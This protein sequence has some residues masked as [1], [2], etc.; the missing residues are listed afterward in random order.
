MTQLKRTLRRH[1][2]LALLLLV[3]IGMAVMLNHVLTDQSLAPVVDNL[4]IPSVEPVSLQTRAPTSSSTYAV[5]TERPLFNPGRR[6]VEA[7]VV[8]A[9]PPAPVKPPVP[10]FPSIEVLGLAQSSRT[11]VAVIRVMSEGR[12]LMLKEGEGLHGWVVSAIDADRIRF[13]RDGEQKDIRMPK[14]Q[15]LNGIGILG[16]SAGTK[17]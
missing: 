13:E 16:K 12:V 5:I 3:N 4:V 1:P 11:A 9:A 6:I 10:A 2:F 15:S 17:P 14:P 7:T 8:A